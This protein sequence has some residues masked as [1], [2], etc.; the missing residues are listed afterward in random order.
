MFGRANATE[1][2]R[3]QAFFDQLQTRLEPG[4]AVYELPYMFFPENP[5][6][7]ALSSYDL[8]EP[9]LRTHGLRWSF[10]GMHGRAGDVW[11]EQVSN[12]EGAELAGA[13]AHAGYGAIYIDR[14]GYVD[15]GVAVERPLAAALGAPL[16]EDAGRS[17]AIYRIPPSFASTGKPFIAVGPGRDWYPWVADSKGD[18]QGWSMGPA[19]LVVANPSTAQPVVVQFSLLSPEMR[20]VHIYYGEQDLGDHAL[21]WAWRKTSS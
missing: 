2:H 5:R 20:H 9:Y 7:A 16:L 17:L 3:Q 14:R 18:P 15:R 21:Q 12:L 1:F 4:T 13:L 6:S 11:N 8:T 19:D 10:G